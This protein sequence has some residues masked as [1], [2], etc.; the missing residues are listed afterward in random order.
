MTIAQP[1]QQIIKFSLQFEG[2]Y[3]NWNGEEYYMGI[4]RKNN[5]NIELWTKLDTIKKFRRV[6]NR[7]IIPELEPLVIDYY[8]SQVFRFCNLLDIFDHSPKYAGILFDFILLH[9]KKVALQLFQQHINLQLKWKTKL[10]VTGIFDSRTYMAMDEPY[11]DW[12]KLA[13]DL[14][15]QHE[16]L[17]IKKTSHGSK[18]RMAVPWTGRVQKVKEHYLE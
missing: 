9:G 16:L 11:L 14:I 12:D 4:S 6:N 10:D 13:W 1:I 17:V 8:Y 15:G 7:E 5:P 18:T 2:G 3:N